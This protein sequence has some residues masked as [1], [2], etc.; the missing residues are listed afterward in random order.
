MF[1]KMNTNSSCSVTQVPCGN[2]IGMPEH[3]WVMVAACIGEYCGE[4]AVALLSA[5]P[6]SFD[7]AALWKESGVSPPQ[8]MALLVELLHRAS[9]GSE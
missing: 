5:S 3:V 1:I 8:E 4:D 2:F 9:Q 6:E 7:T